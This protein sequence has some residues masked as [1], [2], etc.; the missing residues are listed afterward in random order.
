[1][2][3]TQ[4]L[5]E[6]IREFQGGVLIVSHDQHLLTS[7]C[8]NIYVVENGGL[9]ELREGNSAEEAFQAYKRAI[10]LGKR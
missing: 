6:A 1:L 10:V 7:V 3:T 8:K 9:E 2:E 4:A 5:I